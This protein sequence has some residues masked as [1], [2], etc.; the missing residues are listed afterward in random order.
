M[1]QRYDIRE[2]GSG[3]TVF[4]IF[5]GEPV[6]ISLVPQTGLDIQDA[7]ELAELLD[8]KA[9]AGVRTLRQ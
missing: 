4:D 1:P 2:D 7:A 6:V 8:H 5:T 3:W 9:F